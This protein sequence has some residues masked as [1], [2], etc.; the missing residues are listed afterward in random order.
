MRS[1]I[2]QLGPAAATGGSHQKSRGAAVADVQDL[3]TKKKGEE[4][5]FTIPSSARKT[6]LGKGGRWQGIT[7]KG[8]M[9]RKIGQTTKQG[10]LSMWME[11]QHV[12]TRIEHS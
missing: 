3:L 4:D 12:A 7:A 5:T 9:N 6:E 1:R 11:N 10:G 2:G 8:K